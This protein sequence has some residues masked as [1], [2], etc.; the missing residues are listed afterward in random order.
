MH[1]LFI[2]P[3]DRLLVALV[4]ITY[5]AIICGIFIIKSSKVLF[6]GKDAFAFRQLFVFQSINLNSSVNT[7]VCQ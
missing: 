5:K 4:L 1:W 6:F 3:F 2:M 7:G